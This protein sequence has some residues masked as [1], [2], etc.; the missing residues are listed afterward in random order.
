MPKV[1]IVLTSESGSDYDDYY[2]QQ[3]IRQGM[4]D[5]E[6]VSQEDLDFLLR[7]KWRI[8]DRQ[9]HGPYVHPMVVVMDDEPVL[10]RIASIKEFVRKEEERQKKEE[11]ERLAKKAAAKLKKEL[12]KKARDEATELELLAELQRKYPKTG[13]AKEVKDGLD[14]S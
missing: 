13:G 2:S 9:K 12:A 5:W 10:D 6:E 8:V 4:T 1:K 14:V 3:I 11:A 7:N